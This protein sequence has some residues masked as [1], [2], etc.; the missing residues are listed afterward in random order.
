MNTI[1][2]TLMNRHGAL[3]NKII[4]TQENQEKNTVSMKKT[5][6]Q[7]AWTKLDIQ[8]DEFLLQWDTTVVRK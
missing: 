5:R 1:T 8:E 6:H 7:K 2:L 4:W 3:R